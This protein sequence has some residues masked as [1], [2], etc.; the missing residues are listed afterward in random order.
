MAEP[1]FFKLAGEVWAYGDGILLDG[2]VDLV[3]GKKAASAMV[4][5]ADPQLELANRLPLPTRD[6][7]IPFELNSAT[8][9]SPFPVTVFPRIVT[10]AVAR[11]T[12][13]PPRPFSRTTFCTKIPVAP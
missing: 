9:A 2:E 12:R 4:E 13:I 11:S 6:T 1:F 5:L 10:S 8:P 3:T 7:K